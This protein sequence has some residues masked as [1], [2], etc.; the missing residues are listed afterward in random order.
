MRRAHAN[1]AGLAG[2][3]R[4]VVLE[5]YAIPMDGQAWVDRMRKINI[6]VN[7]FDTISLCLLKR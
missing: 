2:F 4:P 5:Q 3:D 6:S 1:L 7:F